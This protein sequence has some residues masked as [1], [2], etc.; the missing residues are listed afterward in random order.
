M[1]FI[2]SS[3]LFSSQK[4]SAEAWENYKHKFIQEDGRVVDYY[5]NAITHTE[6]IGYTLYFSYKLNDTKTFT[7]VYSWYKNNIKKNRYN[8]PGWK[9]GQNQNKEWGML[10]LTSATDS[11]LWI[12]YS[13]MLMNEKKPN[14]MYAFDAQE[15]LK[16]VKKHQIVTLNARTYL[17]P[18]EKQLNNNQNI[19]L[20]PSYFIFEIFEYL[21]KKEND[22]IWSNLIRSSK[23]LLKEARFSSLEL[24]SDWFIY[25]IKERK[26]APL[27][28][29]I[30]FG[31]DA[32]RIPL[33]ILRSSLTKIE[34]KA[35][36]KPYKNYVKMMKDYPLGVVNLS[37]GSISLY[38]LSYG[39]LAIYIKLGKYFSLNVSN[40]EKI[41]KHRMTEDNENY[42]AY[43]LYLLTIL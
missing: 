32:I 17:L 13:L 11:N 9:W 39:H 43:S 24:N 29:D 23:Q 15:L 28:K 6:A 30:L 5:N 3:L 40:L 33:H 8:L 37:K 1:L 38:N 42:Y 36:L 27:K 20:N 7:K 22:Q 21:A 10:D 12:A 26:Q 2:F 18:W 19:K 34:K 31:Y 35:L 41:L 25:N 14:E 4:T 16:A